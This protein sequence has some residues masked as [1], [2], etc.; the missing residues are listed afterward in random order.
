MVRVGK[1]EKKTRILQNVMALRMAFLQDLTHTSSR[2]PSGTCHPTPIP[3]SSPTVAFAIISITR[4]VI[5]DS[6]IS[7]PALSGAPGTGTICRV[8]QLL[9]C[10]RLRVDALEMCVNAEPRVFMECP[11]RPSAVSGA[12]PGVRLSVKAVPGENNV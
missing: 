10:S 8:P 12:G 11:H 7:L 9:A 1:G 6:P 5:P 2:K 4:L 3:S